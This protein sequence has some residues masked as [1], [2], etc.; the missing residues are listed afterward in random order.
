MSFSLFYIYT[1]KSSKPWFKRN[2]LLNFYAFKMERLSSS[3]AEKK[4]YLKFNKK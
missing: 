3:C 4:I 1:Q 2:T